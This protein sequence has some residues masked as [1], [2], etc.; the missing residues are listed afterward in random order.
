[1]RFVKKEDEFG[2]VEIAGLG[3]IFE[4][5]R[6]QPQKKRRVNLWRIDQLIGSKQV[7]HALA[8]NRLH[9]IVELYGGFSKKRFG[10]L[11][12]KLQ[13]TALYRA[14]RCLRNVSVL[15]R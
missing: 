6:Q 5:L 2:F 1:M 13:Q 10:T 11:L 9:K 3:Q 4:K 8:R 7:E 14:D 15:R 12:I